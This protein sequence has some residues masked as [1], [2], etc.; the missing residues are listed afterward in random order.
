MRGD[1]GYRLFIDGK[2]IIDRNSGTPLEQAFASVDL[3]AGTHVFYIEYY[4]HIGNATADFQYYV[5]PKI[6]RPGE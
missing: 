3:S 4:E 5:G 6:W 2:L 1:D